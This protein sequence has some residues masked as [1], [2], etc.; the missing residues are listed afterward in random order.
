[1]GNILKYWL[2]VLVSLLISVVLIMHSAGIVRLGMLDR[3]EA[4]SYDAR[5]LMTLPHEI[6]PRIVIIDIDEASLKQI[7]RW[8]WGRDQMALLTESLFTRYKVATV[9]FDVVF[10][11]T[12]TSSG[13]PALTQ[14]AN[15]QFKHDAEFQHVLN[16]LR[17]SL[18]YDGRFAQ[19]LS[20]GPSVL[21]YYF[22]PYVQNLGQLP[23]P[24]LK[25][26]RAS[27]LQLLQVK[28]YGANLVR[29]QQSA[30]GAGYFNMSADFDGV[31]RRMP[32]LSSYQGA[33]YPSLSLATLQAAMQTHLQIKNITESPFNTR[34][35]ALAADDMFIP[36]DKRGA[37]LVPYRAYPGYTYLSAV[38]VMTGRAPAD[39][40]E[41]AIALVGTTA[42]GLLD[43]R[44]TPVAK[45]YPGVEIHANLISGIL[46]GAL[47]YQPGYAHMLEMALLLIL[48][49]LLALILPR[50]SP[51]RGALLSMSLAAVY[52]GLVAWAWQHGS[53]LNVAPVMVLILGLMI[54][55]MAWGY[56]AESLAKR[57]ITG[58]FG[59]YV[60]P[61]LV[62]EMSH[63][64]SK[65]NMR[66]ESKDLSILFSDVRGFTTVSET[67]TPQQLSDLLNEFL[68]SMTAVIHAH[69]GTID[70]YM[71]DCV[72]AFWGAPLDNMY[73]A[74]DA[75][76][77]GLAMQEELA[78]LNLSFAARGWPQLHVGVGVNTGRVSVGNMGSKFRMAYTVM[79][80]AVNLA[81]RLE[82]ITKQ[83]DVPMVVGEE[84]F[85]VLP[86]M[87]FV[88]LDSVRVKG[89]LKPV[90]IYQPLGL[91]AD[92]SPHVLA[93][94][95]DFS[96][97][98]KAYRTQH[99][100]VAQSKLAAMI[101]RAQAE[102][103][104]VGLYQIYLDRIIYFR[105]H[106]PAADWDGVWV[107]ASK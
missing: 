104:P 37:V 78:Q 15:T 101:I 102:N 59:Q 32:M 35:V 12:D 27:A 3:L 23:Q 38:D 22:T 87:A 63:D 88:E 4:W 55:N 43:L 100:D 5:L 2:R 34:H 45:N 77:A 39:L 21:G 95:S 51:L 98:L 19:A 106:P 11:E 54:L 60:P 13:L 107:F 69:Q 91:R 61:E 9:G 44:V 67:L 105:E 94:A 16:Q 89:K 20:L 29:L 6:D 90:I 96:E 97:V 65:F 71:G 85:A 68:S 75:V 57:Q 66:S 50:L 33:L 79:G 8:P 76:L 10:A 81:S 40:L 58:L 25:S 46:D 64:P 86:E 74:R 48:G 36:V 1:M 17:P 26:Q 73:H 53:V 41:N 93:L 72:M 31:T 42:P 28:G 30:T 24:M 62:D 7:G 18:D 99:W 47:R 92:V 70:K 56:F 80:D 83:Y 14:L 49:M 84:T 103:V 82:G 52:L